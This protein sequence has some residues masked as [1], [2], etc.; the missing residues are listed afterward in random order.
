MKKIL[1]IEDE[2]YQREL[3]KKI[4]TQAGFKFKALEDPD[5]ALEIIKQEKPD[6][7][8]LDLVFS[9]NGQ[10]HMEKSREKG[11]QFLQK[12]KKDSEIKKIPIIMVSNLSDKG[13]HKARALELGVDEFL[14]KA[15]ILPHELVAIV[16][17]VL[18]P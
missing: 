7:I 15:K 5:G 12:L 10:L 1:F 3:Y 9:I 18:K 4:F 11:F 14:N 16:K 2:K 13:K 8:L 6:L 17:G